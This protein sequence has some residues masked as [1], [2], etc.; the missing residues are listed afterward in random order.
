MTQETDQEQE[1]DRQ[2]IFDEIFSKLMDKF[3]EACQNEKITNAIAIAKHPDFD[4]PMVFY[5]APHIIDAATLMA[6]V[7]R[8]VKTQINNDLNTE[9]E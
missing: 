8:Q 3:G 7:L 6:T 1:Q 4:Q 2:A 9:A 5:V